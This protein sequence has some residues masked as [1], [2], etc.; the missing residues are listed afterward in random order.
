MPEMTNMLCISRLNIV[1]MTHADFLVVQLFMTFGFVLAQ[2]Y[3]AI[4]QTFLQSVESIDSNN[5]V[6]IINMQPYHVD[7]SSSS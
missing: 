2:S 7:V 3:R 1:R 5:I 6:K 4:Q